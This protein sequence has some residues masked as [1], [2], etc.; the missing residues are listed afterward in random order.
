[1]DEAQLQAEIENAALSTRIAVFEKIGEAEEAA[2]LR[3]AAIEKKVDGLRQLALLLGALAVIFGLSGA[4]GFKMLSNARAE[5]ANLTSD[6][7]K[8]SGQVNEWDD[9]RLK[10][11]SELE[12]LKIAA[13]DEARAAIV[14]S[15]DRSRGDISDSS[16]AELEKIKNARNEIVA[17]ANREKDNLSRAVRLEIRNKTLSSIK[18]RRLL[19]VDSNGKTMFR[20]GTSSN[21]GLV[22]LYSNTGEEI[23]VFGTDSPGHGGLW[24]KDKE[25]RIGIA[26]S[27]SREGDGYHLSVKNRLT[28]K[29]VAAIGSDIQGDGGVWVSDSAGNGAASMNSGER[30]GYFRIFKPNKGKDPTRLGTFGIS[31]SGAG[32][33]WLYN[34]N[35]KEIFRNPVKN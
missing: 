28:G 35:G 27:S 3:E 26:I 13:I 25:G 21:G 7:G 9:L 17:L 31:S 8:I 11:A 29:Q 15:A 24:L 32:G 4:W 16:L 2:K 12:D 10:Y 20:A 34:P 18:T 23:A 30:G 14:A 6:L 19:V 1:M 33:L 5:L 22:K